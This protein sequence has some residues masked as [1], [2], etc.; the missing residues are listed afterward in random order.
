MTD[1]HSIR[2]AEQR[3]AT[4]ADQTEKQALLNGEAVVDAGVQDDIIAEAIDE[5]Q[6]QPDIAGLDAEIAGRE[7]WHRRDLNVDGEASEVAQEIHRR[8][9]FLGGAY[10]FELDGNSLRYRGPTSGFYEYCLSISV[11]PNITTGEFVRLPR[12]FE[13]VVAILTQLH[14]GCESDFM[15]TGH[16]RDGDL[17]TFRSAMEELARRT[18]E[19]NWGPNEGLPEEPTVAG[20]GGVDFVVWKKPGD[21]RP[22]SLFILG[23]CAC[24]DDW[25]S[26][27]LD[28]DLNELRTWFKPLS[29]VEPIRAFATPFALSDGN[30]QR[31]QVKAGW[32][33]DRIRLTA[34]AELAKDN[35]EYVAWR[36]QLNEIID[37]SLA[38]AA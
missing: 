16:P 34:F 25:S 21:Q 4:D 38:R 33:L 22:G 20:D 31:A 15:H 13:R 17:G 1:R 30:F 37:L 29:Y 32:V 10:P 9:A 28:L 36:D 27:L 24:G 11:A 35:P 5:E 7:R 26:K 6:H 8:R 2:H 18:G 19:W 12:T 3:A 14:M 23:Q